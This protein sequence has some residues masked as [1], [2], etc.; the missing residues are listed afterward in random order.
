MIQFFDVAKSQLANKDF[1]AEALYF[2]NDTGE[3]FFDSKQENSRVQV[4]NEIVILSKES[5]R[6]ALL[7]PIPEKLYLVV[8]TGRSYLYTDGSWIA[9][10][11]SSQIHFSN[12]VLTSDGTSATL[13]ISDNRIKAT[14]TA[15]FVPDLSVI[16]L[17]T[18][19]KATCSAGSVIVTATAKY[20]IPGEVVVN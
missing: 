20:D 5:D 10:G 4:G 8:D 1:E 2:C 19:V 18:N 7:A 15:T 14:D 13:T 3:I 11:S 12:Q 6:T 9:I 17:A 16:D